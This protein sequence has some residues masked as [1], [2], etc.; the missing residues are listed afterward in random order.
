MISTYQSVLVCRLYSKLTNRLIDDV[1]VPLKHLCLL[2]EEL[3]AL[4]II[5]LFDCGKKAFDNRMETTS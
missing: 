3:V 1:A 5:M 2:P 4:K